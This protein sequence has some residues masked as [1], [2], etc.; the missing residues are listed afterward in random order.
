MTARYF[1]RKAYGSIQGSKMMFMT[2]FSM[3]APVYAGWVHD[4]TG[5]YVN[6]ISLLTVLGF[7]STVIICFVLPPK[8]PAEVTD[9]RK[10]T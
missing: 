7:I 9:I 5:S 4:T 1:G 2:P 8:P 6:A 3:V 10:I